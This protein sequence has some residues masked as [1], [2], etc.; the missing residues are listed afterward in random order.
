MMTSVAD[1]T[2]PV[3]RG[4]WIMQVMLGSPPPPPPPNVPTLDAT[5]AA[6]DGKVLSVRER[7]EQH[8]ANPACMSCHRVIDPLGL[9]L[10]HFDV[11]GQYRIK[12]NGV[13]VDANGEMYDGTKMQGAEGLRQAL[14]GKKDAMLTSF[15]ES[16]MTYALGRRVESFDMPALRAI[17]RDAAKQDY[18]ISALVQGVVRSQPFRMSKPQPSTATT[19][20]VAAR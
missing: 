8:R 1:R 17:V 7:M 15:T 9:A 14:L 5:A 13:P 6:Q 3:Q 11:T 4:K 19:N 10:E 16:L 12:D 20:E 18:R 2:S